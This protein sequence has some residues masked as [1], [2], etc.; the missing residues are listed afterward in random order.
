MNTVV[1]K[2]ITGFALTAALLSACTTSQVV[3][4]NQ[5]GDEAK[6]CDELKIAIAEAQDF[7]RKARKNKG[8]TGTNVAAAVFFWPAMIATYTS[9]EEAEDAAR[10]RQSKLVM[11]ANQKGCK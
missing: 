2:K 10:E 3:Q 1:M 4:T 8:V 7:E 6:S 5:I 9:A 11:I